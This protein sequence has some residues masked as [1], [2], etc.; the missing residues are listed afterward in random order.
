M[1]QMSV[2][3]LMTLTGML[4]YESSVSL[5]VRNT[6]TG[7]GLNGKLNKIEIVKILQSGGTKNNTL[8]T[9]WYVELGE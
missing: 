6:G 4:R 3:S 7:C 9:I 8:I 5:S 1:S 2:F